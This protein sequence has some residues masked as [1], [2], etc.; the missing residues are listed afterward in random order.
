M[1]RIGPMPQGG[2]LQGALAA[3]RSGDQEALLQHATWCATIT[4]RTYTQMVW[5]LDSLIVYAKA[6]GEPA[7]PQWQPRP[8]SLDPRATL[9]ASA[10]WVLRASAAAL[11]GEPWGSFEAGSLLNVATIV[12]QL[13]RHGALEGQAASGWLSLAQHCIDRPCRRS[14][15]LID[16]PQLDMAAIAFQVALPIEACI[17]RIAAAVVL[18]G[19]HAAQLR[20]LQSLAREIA[21]IH[22]RIHDDGRLWLDVLLAHGDPAPTR[23]A[24]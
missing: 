10:Q 13:G 17:L 7:A 3:L 8:V 2:I 21:S 4:G 15:I 19:D 22:H 9:G 23:G 6:H 5:A 24:S 14:S 16:L 12:A 1:N 18:G 11:T 20:P